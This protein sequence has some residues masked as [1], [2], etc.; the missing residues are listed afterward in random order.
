MVF[1][2]GGT[3]LLG[4]YLLR[5]LTARGEKVIALYRKEIPPTN[6]SNQ[7][8]WIKG[9]IHDVVLLEEIMQEVQQV[10]HCAATVS[11]NPQKKY[12]LLKVNA[13]GTANIVNA[14]LKTGIQK[15]VH[16]SS[17][18]ALGRKRDNMQVTEATRW[19][20]DSNNSD[21]GRSK[22][23]AELEV[24]RGIS[25][26]LNAV[27][28]NPTLIL[29]VG[30]WETGSSAIFKKAWNQFPWYTEGISGIVD[31]ADVAT[32]MILLMESDITNE[33]FIISAE[34]W[35]FKKLFTAMAAAFGKKPPYKKVSP[36]MAGLLWR[37]EKIRGWFTGG[38]PLLTKTATDTAARKVYF[39][40]SKL[41]GALPHFIYK[42]L[43]QTIE[44]YCNAYKTMQ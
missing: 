8:Q 44:E 4:S 33:R 25:E 35:S 7:V 29:G 3:G 16:V 27:I 12:E 38:E 21:Y 2:T 1:V 39:D 17:V 41:L 40:S 11:F 42:P 30:N 28:V 6:Y 31:A 32:A 22:Y 10:Y 34:N 24:W 43:Q 20:E 14:A 13:E 23:Y 18:S 5:E 26:G 9:D 36:Y 37:I 15:L 19:E